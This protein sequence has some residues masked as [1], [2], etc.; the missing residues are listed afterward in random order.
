M[1]VAEPEPTESDMC[2]AKR[3]RDLGCFGMCDYFDKQVAKWDRKNEQSIRN[4]STK[5]D[6][7]IRL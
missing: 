4:G 5:S 3:C 2:G 1:S 7:P 6:T